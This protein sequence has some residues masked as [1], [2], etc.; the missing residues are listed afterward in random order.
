M[1][2]EFG[3]NPSVTEQGPLLP[4][5]IGF[6]AAPHLWFL[7]ESGNPLTE[8]FWVSEP[9]LWCAVGGV[10]HVGVTSM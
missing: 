1:C 9:F 8:A 10:C 6:V 3:H 5:E 4:W 7:P 2:T